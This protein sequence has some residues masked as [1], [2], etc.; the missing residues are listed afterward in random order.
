MQLTNEQAR[1]MIDIGHVH[2]AKRAAQQEFI[3]TCRYGARWRRINGG[4]YLYFGEQSKGARSAD[5]EA[6]YTAYIGAREALQTRIAKL[7]AKLE[8]MAPVNVALKLGRVP[9]LPA[10]ILRA[11][12][13][14]G[15]LGRHLRVIG[16]HVLFAYEA[17]AGDYF[18]SDLLAT[19]DL[20]LCWDARERLVI[21]AEDGSQRTVLSILK[22]VD[23]SF[24]AG[25]LYG[26]GAANDENFIV[27]L[28]SPRREDSSP[29]TGIA[30]DVAAQPI[31]EV[32]ALTGQAFSA[33]AIGEDG[34][35]VQIVCPL[36]DVFVEHKLAISK[37]SGRKPLQQRRD[38][39][40]AAAVAKIAP[41]L[42]A[43]GQMYRER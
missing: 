42:N 27:D 24:D 19:T 34:L 15:L 31:P 35:P 18:Q 28:I 43:T 1:Q 39:A 4:D 9:K 10:K 17:A 7:R 41:V 14:E 2:A 22:R 33:M 25:R 12:D 37:A 3:R 23:R 32:E 11:L 26:F 8:D 16:T 30:G 13:R 6:A 5:T 29:A 40:Q 38:A 36:P 21:L 20:D